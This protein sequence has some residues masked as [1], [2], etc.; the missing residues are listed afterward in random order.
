MSI[1]NI[2]QPNNLTLYAGAIETESL[3]INSI[4]AQSIEAQTIE[5][6]SMQAQTIEAQSIESQTIETPSLTFTN[7]NT[8]ITQ[9]NEY[10]GTLPVN[11]YTTPATANYVATRVGNLVNIMVNAPIL[12]VQGSTY[13]TI[14]PIPVN[15]RPILVPPVFVY[16]AFSDPNYF[17][18]IGEVQTNGDIVLYAGMEFNTRFPANSQSGPSPPSYWFTITYTLG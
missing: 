5:T 15:L 2:L 18:A 8:S 16:S 4:T 10:N 7:S 6:Q 13:I 17:S 3:I 1:Q 11:G 9:Y 14:G 12:V